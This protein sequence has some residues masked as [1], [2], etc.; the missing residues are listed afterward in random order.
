ML[1][2]KVT[3]AGAKKPTSCDS[4]AEANARLQVARD[5]REVQ[6]NRLRELKLAAKRSREQE[7]ELTTEKEVATNG[8]SQEESL[9]DVT[10]SP[11]KSRLGKQRL[12]AFIPTH[13]IIIMSLCCFLY[14]AARTPKV[15]STGR[16][17][18]RSE[19]LLSRSV[20]SPMEVVKPTALC[21]SE[22][23]TGSLIS[24]Y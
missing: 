12:C 5:R 13:N 11:K 16:I 1:L 3:K 20:F 21:A 4:S 18:R 23:P 10:P 22:V 8:E 14:Y 2:Q 9:R 24:L 6:R 19:R 7:A 15:D 17:R